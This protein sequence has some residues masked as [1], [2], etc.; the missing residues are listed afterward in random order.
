MYSSVTERHGD[1]VGRVA[2]A[3]AHQNVVFVFRARAFLV[4]WSALQ[5]CRLQ[6]ASVWKVMM[7]PQHCAVFSF[8][9]VRANSPLSP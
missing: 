2:R 8:A 7:T 6:I 3:N 4:H 5:W 1:V 9:R